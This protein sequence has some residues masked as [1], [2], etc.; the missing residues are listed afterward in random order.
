MSRHQLQQHTWAF[1]LVLSVVLCGCASTPAPVI[2]ADASPSR[3]P[4]AQAIAS[5]PNGPSSPQSGESGQGTHSEGSREQSWES[6]VIQGN[7]TPSMRPSVAT[8]ASA[9]PS[10]SPSAAVSSNLPDRFDG[11]VDRLVKDACTAPKGAVDDGWR[12]V[13]V[14]GRAPESQN[15]EDWKHFGL[16]VDPVCFTGGASPTISNPGGELYWLRVHDEVR[17][18]C[19]EGL[20]PCALGLFRR[21]L[22]PYPPS[23]QP[24]GERQWP[25][26]AIRVTGGKIDRVEEIV[27]PGDVPRSSTPG[28][29]P[30][31]GVAGDPVAQPGGH[32][33]GTLG[34]G[35]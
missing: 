31:P 21:T 5:I 11:K 12:V 28:I 2:P 24:L 14:G 22:P 1:A 6:T 9:S 33:P 15:A 8:S 30:A 29:Q 19:A 17:Y 3:D 25:V 27:M 18:A 35:E 10:V 32:P 26:A 13:M 16:L 4:S 20:S 34:A 7:P 23:K